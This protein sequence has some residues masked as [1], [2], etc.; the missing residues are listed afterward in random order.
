MRQ[1]KNAR[2]VSVPV[3]VKTALALRCC[4]A[5]ELARRDDADRIAMIVRTATVI[6]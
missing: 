3:Y 5:P 2:A 4:A 1:L 6:C